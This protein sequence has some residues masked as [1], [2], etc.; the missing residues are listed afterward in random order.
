M[1]RI[2]VFLTAAAGVHA[3]VIQGVVLENASGRPMARTMVRL[4]PVPHSGGGEARPLTTRSGRSGHFVFSA[5]QPGLYLLAAVNDGY[6]PAAYGQRL[7]IGRGTPIQVTAESDL[8]AQLRLRHKGALTGRVLDE[9]GIGTAGVPVLAYRARLPLRSAGSAVSD[10]RGVFRI[11]GL[12]PGKYWARSGAHILNDGSGWLPTFAPQGREVRDARV[13][14]VTV[15]ADTTDAD[16]SPEPGTLFHL[17][18]LIQCDANGQANVTL[19]SET[20]HRN[21]KVAC[22]TAY[23]FEG[24]APAVYEVFAA[25]QDGTASGFS[26]LFLDR[27]NDAGSIQLLQVPAVNIEVQ[28]R[29]SSPAADSSVK[30]TGRRRDLSESQDEREIAVPRTTLDP[31]HWELRAQPPRGQYVESIANLLGPPRRLWNAPP[32]S[33]WYE[34]FVQQRYPSRIR[35]T[36]SD[37]ASQITGRVVT[38]GQPVPGV[39]VFLWPVADSTRRS[40]RGPLQTLSTAEGQ[41]HFDSLPPGDYRILA[42]FDVN[43][44]DEELL[45][46]SRASTVH[47]DALQVTN[48]E[49]ALWIAP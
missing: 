28:R 7:P 48:T 46:M 15:D 31:G 11:S 27:D 21:T 36:V 35:I 18:G 30:L 5:V 13:Y 45:E 6:F 22:N 19:S 8:F 23:R 39:P 42:S 3:G 38:D 4:D 37:Q 24:L 40:L 9:N 12:D 10:D 14:Q 26:E 32:A 16:V 17:S 43:D 20:G 2:L 49:V 41:F 25:R 1:H 34:V 44:I 47:V 33:D 29:G